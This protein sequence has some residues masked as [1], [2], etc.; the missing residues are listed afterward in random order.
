[1]LPSGYT[2]QLVDETRVSIAAQ[3][4]ERE[5]DK[6]FFRTAHVR[7]Q[8]N[9]ESRLNRLDSE[10]AIR[11]FW[12]L[13]YVLTM[14]VKLKD[15]VKEITSMRIDWSFEEN[16]SLGPL[17]MTGRYPR[18]DFSGCSFAQA[19]EMLQS[20][21]ELKKD[22]LAEM[23]TIYDHRIDSLY[24]PIVVIEYEGVRQVIDGNGR[25]CAHIHGMARCTKAFVGRY[26]QRNETQHW[27]ATSLILELMQLA[28]E[29][30]DLTALCHLLRE[31]D[32]ALYS[33][34]SFEPEGSE[35]RDNVLKRIQPAIR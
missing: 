13:A 29:T 28:R 5:L 3:L 34:L 12:N 14:G 20:D 6:L 31:S 8:A 16:I 7:G 22:E 26:V 19:E 2:P 27:V 17:V 9:R 18:V 21:P 33:F 1:M 30:G 15:I 11:D 32:N 25:L 4:I 10:V 23:H 35:L 24:E